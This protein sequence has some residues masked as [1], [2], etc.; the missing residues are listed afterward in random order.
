MRPP[1]ADGREASC[2]AASESGSI[3]AHGPGIREKGKI[4]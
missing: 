1:C 3:G 4:R 2:D